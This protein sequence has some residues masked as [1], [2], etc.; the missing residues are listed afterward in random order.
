MV[1]FQALAA[2]QPVLVGMY[3]V[4]LNCKQP[5]A[6]KNT[7]PAVW[8]VL[9]NQRRF[10]VAAFSLAAPSSGGIRSLLCCRVLV[11]RITNRK[12]LTADAPGGE[13]GLIG[14]L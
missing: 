3:F 9:C 2:V 5:L 7:K 4:G 10:F 1:E 13:E 8:R 11:L 6:S 12:A 14:S